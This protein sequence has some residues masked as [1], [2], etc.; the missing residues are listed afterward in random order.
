MNS[1]LNGIRAK[2]MKCEVV[3]CLRMVEERKAMLL[4]Y[5]RNHCFSGGETNKDFRWQISVEPSSQRKSTVT[6]YHEPE[7][8]E[9]VSIL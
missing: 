3:N 8:N 9:Q 5:Q 4:P 7:Y 2:L 6:F 1:Q